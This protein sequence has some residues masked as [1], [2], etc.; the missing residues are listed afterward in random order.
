MRIMEN[1][2]TES[3]ALEN[4]DNPKAC[5]GIS[6]TNGLPSS[7]S[8]NSNN[9]HPPSQQKQVLSCEYFR[10]FLIYLGQKY[11]EFLQDN[12]EDEAGYKVLMEVI[13]CRM[14]L[15]N[16]PLARRIERLRLDE[17]EQPRNNN[18]KFQ[19]SKTTTTVLAPARPN[20]APRLSFITTN[21]RRHWPNVSATSTS[22]LVVGS[23]K[24][25]DP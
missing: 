12:P 16:R 10:N 18:N 14:Y 19:I 3:K 6:V 2:N 20:I 24:I 4:G 1:N 25:C 13:Y 11:V 5:N 7:H 23:R 8:V 9:L 15:L 21:P 22:R 17:L